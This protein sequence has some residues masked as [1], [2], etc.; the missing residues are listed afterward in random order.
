MNILV[1]GPPM[2]RGENGM[3]LYRSK[4]NHQVRY[5][6]VEGDADFAFAPLE[7]TSEVIA[8][9]ARTWVPDLFLCWFPE[10]YPPPCAIEDCPIP[11]VAAVSDWNIYASQFEHNLSRYDLVLTDKKAS[12][13]L[14]APGATL[15]YV[16]PL[17]SQR[18]RLHR[19]LNT[20]R[21][22]DIFFAGNLNHAIHVERGH[23]LEKVAALSDRYRVVICHGHFD[24][25]YN[26]L[27][28]RARIV[29]NYSVR[30]EMNLRCFETLA[31][32]ALLFV[33]ES[34]LEVRQ[35]LNDR[36]EMVLYRP[37][38]LQE[39][40]IHY[41]EN[42]AERKQIAEAGQVLA[43]PLALENR[44]DVLFDLLSRLKCGPRPFKTLSEPERIFADILQYGS[45]LAQIQRTDA[46]DALQRGLENYPD[47]AEFHAAAGCMLFEDLSRGVPGDRREIV[48]QLTECFQRAC[49]LAPD[50]IPLLLNMAQVCRAGKVRQGERFFLERALAAR[51]TKLGGLL[52]GTVTDPYYAAWR[53]L[54]ALNEPR[55]ELLWADAAMRL[56]R[57]FVEQESWGDA[58]N[59][60]MRS[61]RY[62]ATIA[63]PYRLGAHAATK[64]GQHVLATEL[65]ERGLPFTSFDADYRMDLVNAWQMHNVLQRANAHAETATRLFGACWDYEKHAETFRKAILHT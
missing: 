24:E 36:Q 56:A 33:E 12:K 22:I 40:L 60:A 13:Q 17:Y 21:D 61:I 4:S 25:A 37:D 11:C 20:P 16:S 8:R 43:E 47:M 18:S 55:V 42:E 46:N 54:L 10:M 30:G 7:T 28:N 45:S 64:Q 51:G 58:F 49:N 35:F 26:Q 50:S 9:I 14:Y 63:T 5:L 39:L 27:M 29:F 59:A 65:L 62:W 41:L 34:N 53:Q 52:L 15:R 6:A 38:N 57:F 2:W 1:M 32:G 3:G 23:C 31:C 19:L 48:R 44:W